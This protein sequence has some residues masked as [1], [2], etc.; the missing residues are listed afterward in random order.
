MANY[1]P[2]VRTGNLVFLAGQG[3]LADGKP[4][5]TGKV[6]A[7]VSEEDAYK[8]ARATILNSRRA[9]PGR[10]RVARQ[11][12]E[13]CEAHGMGQ[14]RAGIHP[15]A[16]RHQRRIR[17]I[18]GNLSGDAGRHARTAVGKRAAVYNIPVEIEIVVEIKP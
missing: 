5:I 10:D 13:N 3:P 4:T 15:A 6:G 12:E 16:V 1:V 2:A 9:A 7:E 14:Q 8:A 18:G 11:G 17:F